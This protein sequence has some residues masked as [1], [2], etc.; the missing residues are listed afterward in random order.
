MSA[1]ADELIPS[2]LSAAGA[3][4]KLVAL[5]IAAGEELDAAYDSGD[6]LGFQRAAQLYR[7]VAEATSRLP[8]PEIPHV[9]T[10]AHV[11]HVLAEEQFFEGNFS[12]ASLGFVAAEATLH[13]VSD[14]HC[15][16]KLRVFYLIEAIEAAAFAA[17]A[18]GNVQ[19]AAHLHQLDLRLT[20]SALGGWSDGLPKL[21]RRLEGHVYYSL[22]RLCLVNAVTSDTGGGREPGGPAGRSP[23]N[24]QGQQVWLMLAV[25]L[26]RYSEKIN[27]MWG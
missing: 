6:A 26:E 25:A 9:V 8:R 15:W 22:S 18:D 27:P 5:A 21:R 16:R 7:S 1:G 11:Q 10:L 17:F 12:A 19:A 24:H 3:D 20:C 13:Q 14:G 23:T 2:L 4:P